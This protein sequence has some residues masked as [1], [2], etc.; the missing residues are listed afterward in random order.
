M[1]QQTS[2]KNKKYQTAL[3][4]YRQKNK[5]GTTKVSPYTRPFKMETNYPSL[6]RNFL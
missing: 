1:A 2:L 6:G 5:Q 4:C 3:F